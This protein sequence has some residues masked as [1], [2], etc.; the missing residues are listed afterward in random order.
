MNVV[1]VGVGALGSHLVLLARNWEASLKIV[2]FDRVESKNTQSQFHTKMGQGKN[3]TVALQA[4]M[5]GMFNRTIASSPVKLEFFNSQALLASS[6]LVIDCTDN[7]ATRNQIQKY[8]KEA[9]IPCLHGCL[10]ADGTLARAIWTEHFIADAEDSSGGATCEDGRN[11]P[12]H[13]LAASI[14]TATAQRFLEEGVKQS[15]HITPTSLLRL[16]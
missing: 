9:N 13:A 5:R 3:K 7:A 12:F 4:A 15:W 16:T 14:L 10:S 8:C 6:D 2:D 1:I 11:L